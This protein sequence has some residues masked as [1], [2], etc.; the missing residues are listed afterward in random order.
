M[1]GHLLQTNTQNKQCFLILYVH[2]LGRRDMVHPWHH[3]HAVV[4]MAFNIT[5]LQAS[6]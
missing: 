4:L 2:E 1:R 5:K 6:A 3:I